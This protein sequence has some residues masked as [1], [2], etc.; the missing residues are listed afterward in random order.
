ME[1]CSSQKGAGRLAD[2]KEA[3]SIFLAGNGW[4]ENIF[5]FSSPYEGEAEGGY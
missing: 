5:F 3:I 4:G 2:W 1:P